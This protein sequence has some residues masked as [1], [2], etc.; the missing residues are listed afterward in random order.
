MKLLAL[1]IQNIELELKK[2]RKYVKVKVQGQNFKYPNYFE[3]YRNR[4]SDHAP[5]ISGQ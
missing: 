3:R 1:G 4:Y 2:I 5:A